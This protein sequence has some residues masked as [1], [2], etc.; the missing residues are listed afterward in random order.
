MCFFPLPVRARLGSDKK[1]EI[2]Q[3]GSAVCIEVTEDD[4]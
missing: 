2:F 1:Y 3:S 4:V